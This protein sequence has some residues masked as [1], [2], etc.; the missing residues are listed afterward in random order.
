MLPP[1]KMLHACSRQ[2]AGHLFLL[3]K[4]YYV[5]PIL[6]QSLAASF[7]IAIKQIVEYFPNRM[8]AG[9]FTSDNF[10]E[11]CMV[12]FTLKCN[13][14]QSQGI[15]SVSVKEFFKGAWIQPDA[16]DM[17]IMLAQDNHKDHAKLHQ[18]DSA[19]FLSLT[20]V[21]TVMGQ[22]LDLTTNAPVAMQTRKDQTGVLLLA[23]TLLQFKMMYFGIDDAFGS[24]DVS[25]EREQRLAENSPI[26]SQGKGNKLFVYITNCQITEDELKRNNIQHSNSIIICANNLK[27]VFSPT[28]EYATAN[29]TSTAIVSL[30]DR[31]ST[32]ELRKPK[33]LK[34]RNSDESESDDRQNKKHKVK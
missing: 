26:R 34:R 7:E 9:Q 1:T 13:L 20:H 31:A 2:H 24:D 32:E 14:L 16:V 4:S 15:H 10:K 17:E 5:P 33:K 22:V 29:I 21:K 27:T 19:E 28:L 25:F 18:T 8:L 23:D 30:E 11:F 12:F 3:N 6:L